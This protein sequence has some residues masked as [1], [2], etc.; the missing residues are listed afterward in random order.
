MKEVPA[1]SI[2]IPMYNAEKFIARCLDSILAQTFQDSEVI[3][4][5]DC[6]TDN[7]FAI[8]K[9]YE[10]KFGGRL[11]LAKTKKNSGGGG[12]VPRNVGLKISRG[13]YIFFV[14]ADDF[15]IE[16]ALEILHAAA[17]QTDAEVVYSAQYYFCD[18]NRNIKFIGDNEAIQK[19]SADT[20]ILSVD[21]SEENCR[22]LFVDNG[23][24][25]MP[26]TKFV[27]R[28]FLVKNKIEFPPI[29]SG[30]DFIWT[31]QVVY[32]AKRFLRL[33]IAIYCYNDNSDSVTRKNRTPAEQIDKCFKAFLLG[34]KTLCALSNKIEVLRKN[35]DYLHTAMRAFLGNYFGRTAEARKNFSL[36]EL[37]EILCEGKTTDLELT[38]AFLF[39]IIDLERNNSLKLQRRVAELEGKE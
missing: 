34:A 27:Q 17:K 20:M 4:V 9:S 32:Y 33:P 12:Y 23:I 38:S 31:I 39:S 1:V 11:K 13:E 15:I 35:K 30:G 3:V 19:G 26:W 8:V 29:I 2:I 10:Y 22:K 21:A 18:E 6:S 28:K 25:H 37:Y 24:Y 16:S 5:D 36:P 7:S 14:D